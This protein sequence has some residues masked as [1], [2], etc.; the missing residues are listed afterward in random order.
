[1]SKN[2]SYN[3]KRDDYVNVEYENYFIVAIFIQA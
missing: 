2:I 1:M 3:F